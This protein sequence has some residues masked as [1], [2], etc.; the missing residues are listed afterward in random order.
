M[1]NVCKHPRPA[2]G[3]FGR[4]SDRLLRSAMGTVPSLDIIFR[5]TAITLFHQ[6]PAGHCNKVTSLTLDN[7]QV[8]NNELAVERYGTKRS[9]TVIH[10]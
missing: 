10:I 3:M 4:R 9:Q 1:S 8:S 6:L 2:A 7:L 5:G